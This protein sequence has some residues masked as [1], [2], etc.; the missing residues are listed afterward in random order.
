MSTLA[1][2]TDQKAKEVLAQCLPF[3]DELRNLETTAKDSHDA[4]QAENILRRIIENNEHKP[5]G[6]T[7]INSVTAR[8]MYALVVWPEVQDLMDYEWFQKECY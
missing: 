4:R 8:E 7:G 6:L 2:Q 1:L 3:F 5:T